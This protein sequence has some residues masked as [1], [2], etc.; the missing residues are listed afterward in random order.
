VSIGVALALAWVGIGTTETL[1]AELICQV[2]QVLD[3][4]HRL[5]MRNLHE[6]EDVVHGPVAALLAD[7]GRCEALQRAI[8]GFTYRAVNLKFHIDQFPM[9]YIRRRPGSDNAQ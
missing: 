3:N 6:K 9:R 5:M 1:N 7:L 2:V 4:N 8:T